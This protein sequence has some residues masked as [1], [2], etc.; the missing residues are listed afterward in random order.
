MVSLLLA[1]GMWQVQM[2]RID[3]LKPAYD[4]ETKTAI[5]LTGYVQSCMLIKH[6]ESSSKA[7][8]KGRDYRGVQLEGQPLCNQ[9]C[10][11]AT[12]YSYKDCEIPANQK[13]LKKKQARRRRHGSYMRMASNIELGRHVKENH[14]DCPDVYPN[15]SPTLRPTICPRV[16]EGTVST[17]TASSLIQAMPLAS[18][19]CGVSAR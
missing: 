10:E 5:L 11:G 2:Y 19:L 12:I 4:T 18:F 6:S 17:S 14:R 1:R 15:Q 3:V 16:V 9:S 8:K 13:I 7:P